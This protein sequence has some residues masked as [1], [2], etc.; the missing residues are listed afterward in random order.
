M[1]TAKQLAAL[2]KARAARKKKTGKKVKAKAAKRK[3]P[4]KMA[5]KRN[6][7]PKKYVVE[8]KVKGG[9]IG[10]LTPNYKLDTDFSEAAKF[11][12]KLAEK[13]ATDFFNYHKSKLIWVK[14]LPIIK[15]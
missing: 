6:P 8:V 3:A 15:K 11:P 2:A 14:V 1:A 12:L 13:E 7:A 5:R 4:K 9:K 10:Y